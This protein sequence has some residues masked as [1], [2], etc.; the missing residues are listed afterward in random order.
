[1]DFGFIVFF[2]GG[3]GIAVVAFLLFLIQGMSSGLQ[4]SIASFVNNNYIGI[5]IV[6][7]IICIIFAILNYVGTKR[8]AFAIGSFILL[9]QLFSN[10]VL[11]IYG[12]AN[13]KDGAFVFILSLIIYI[14]I[15]I[16]DI[17]LSFGAYIVS[18]ETSLPLYIGGIVGLVISVGFW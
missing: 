1:M 4:E 7:S 10:I 11:G 9:V 16:A 2:G 8:I 17:A 13:S 5:I 3:G 18:E 12:I 15:I 6:L 14:A